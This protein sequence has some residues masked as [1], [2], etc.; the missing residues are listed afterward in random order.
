MKMTDYTAQGT[1]IQIVLAE[2]DDVDAKGVVRTFRHAKIS[3][4][5]FR[6]RDGVEA[7]EL[8]RDNGKKAIPCPRHLLVDI[9]MPRM[10][11]IE[12]IQALRDDPLL[13][14]TVVFVLTTSNRDEDKVAAYNLNVAGY[15]VK[16]KAGEDFL[17]LV[18]M[19]D[20]YWK[21]VEMPE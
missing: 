5:I 10:N 17:N 4:P 7:L 12:L 6:A 8:L 1:P 15:I 9:N 3:N 19:L 21:I 16:E 14:P 2:D 13:K 11:G 18:N 20:L